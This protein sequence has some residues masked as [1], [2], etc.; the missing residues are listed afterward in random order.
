[1]NNNNTLLITTS[2][3]AQHES[4]M[5]VYFTNG[6]DKHIEGGVTYVNKVF[7]VL[8]KIGKGSFWSVRKVRRNVVNANGDVVDNDYYV[9]KKGVLNKHSFVMGMSLISDSGDDDNDDRIGI[10]EYKILKTICNKNIARLYECIVDYNK[11]KVCLIMDYC[12][13]GS[14]MLIEYDEQT[15]ED[16][17]VYNDKVMNYLYNEYNKQTHNTTN[18]HNIN[19]TTDITYNNKEHMR[20]LE[21]ASSEIF[22]QLLS[23]LSYLHYTKLIAHLDIKPDNVLLKSNETSFNTVVKLSDFSISRKFTNINTTADI[24]GGTYIYEAPEIKTGN[25]AS[26]FKC[27]VY[28]LGRTIYSFLFQTINFDNYEHNLSLITTLPL[29]TALTLSMKTD[30]NERADVQA[31]QTLFHTTS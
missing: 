23:A 1:M 25:E 2:P 10:K 8:N 15:K 12:D 21:W 4:E 6:Y 14:L 20:F 26:P 3:K 29:Q 7:Q 13:L 22:K 18:I 19:T 31:L 9:I 17:F 28:S 16:K 11:N 30:P 5:K 27:D 24:I